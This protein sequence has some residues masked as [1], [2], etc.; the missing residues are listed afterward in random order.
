MRLVHLQ[1]SLLAKVTRRRSRRGVYKQR[2]PPQRGAVAYYPLSGLI[3]LVYAYLPSLLAYQRERLNSRRGSRGLAS[4]TVRAR[5]SNSL[6]LSPWMATLAAWLS[7]ISTN[8]KPLERPVSRSVIT[9]ILST[10][11]YCSKSWRRS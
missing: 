6:P 8:P 3:Q 2:R 11:P 7:G 1:G 5:P 9:L 10:A 4:L